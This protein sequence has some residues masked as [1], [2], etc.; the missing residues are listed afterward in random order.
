MATCFMRSR[1]DV[2]SLAPGPDLVAVTT[3][4]VSECEM[5]TLVVTATKS[6]P[7]A[8]E[9]SARERMKQVAIAIDPRGNGVLIHPINMDT[10]PGGVSVDIDVRVPKSSSLAIDAAHGDVSVSGVSGSIDVR[11]GKWRHHGSQCRL[12]R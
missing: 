5:H 3:R 9:T 8:S 4:A 10:A 6:G 12:G 1:A 11:S 2:F 7:G